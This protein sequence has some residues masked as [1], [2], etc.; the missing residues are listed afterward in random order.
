MKRILIIGNYGIDNKLNGQTARTRTI[1]KTMTKIYTSCKIETIDTNNITLKQIVRFIIYSFKAD[2]IVIMCARKS[3]IPIMNFLN[4]FHLLNKTI[5][6]VIGGWLYEY[7]LIHQKLIKKLKKLKSILV[8]TNGIK[9]ELLKIGV[10]SNT[11]VNYRIYDT[12][13]ELK[14]KT[15]KYVFYSRIREDKGII[16]AIDAINL[17][18]KQ[19]EVYLDIYGCIDE[20]FKTTFYKKIQNNKY[21]NYCGILN[22]NNEILETLSKYKCMLLP[23]LYDGEGYPGTILHSFAADVPV[24]ASN[25]IYN[26]EII[27]NGITGLIMKENTAYELKRNIEIIENGVIDIKKLEKN[28]IKES[29]K[30]NEKEAIRILK[31]H[32]E[33]K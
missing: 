16:K 2:R 20:N 33:K 4:F 7:S 18:N 25:W 10:K 14:K 28:C 6:V 9:E 21:I 19:K 31:K 24:S 5:Y 32:I 1:T 8:Q 17:I 13:I 12:K 22:N 15:N 3:I 23:T 27:K 30:F 26:E 11:L 29:K